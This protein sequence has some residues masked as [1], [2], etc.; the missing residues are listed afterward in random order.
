MASKQVLPSRMALQQTKVRLKGAKKGHELLKKKADALKKTF[1]TVML[2]IIDFKKRMGK[3]FSEA[4]FA[5]AEANFAAGDFGN[6]LADQ[7]KS[8]SNIRLTVAATN[9]AGVHLP[10]FALRGEEQE[11][12]D[13]KTMLGLTGGGKAIT[14]C[15]DKFMN[16]LKLLTEIASYQTQFITLDEVIKVTNRRVNGLEYVVIPRIA[17]NI[18][19]IE[20]ELDE[21]EREDFFRLKRVTD[22]KKEAKLQEFL[23][24]QAAQEK[25][26][27][28]GKTEDDHT[29]EVAEG[30]GASIFENDDDDGLVF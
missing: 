1:R 26:A 13:D 18:K 15:R 4:M 16:F 21:M 24:K 22:K 9:V 17:N 23:E 25:A 5:L 14:K 8:R 6:N 11:K 29:D 3:E 20:K 28:A 12:S 2:A 30:E 10:K 19:W 27:A 7:V